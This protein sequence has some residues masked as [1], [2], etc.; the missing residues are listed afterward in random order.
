MKSVSVR[1][2]APQKLAMRRLRVGVTLFIR[3]GSQ[4]IWENGIFQNC[5]FLIALLQKSPVVETCYIVNGGPGDPANTGNFAA[6]A[7]SEIIS[8]DAAQNQLDV[9]IELSAQLDPEWGR[10]FVHKGGRIVGM[11][12]AND[13]VIDA[14]RIAFNLEPGL[15]MSGTPYQ[16]LW[17]LPAFE[18]TCAGYYAAATGRPVRVMQH[19]WSPT[20]LE[21]S[22][23]AAGTRHFAYAP[24][25]KRWRVAIME[26]N[27]CSV[28][29]CH[30]PLLACDVAHRMNSQ[31]LEVVRVFN[32]LPLKEN[33]TFV[34]FARSTDL[35]RQGLATFEG[36]YPIANIMG[37]MADAIVSHHWH[38]AQNYLYYEALYGGYPLIHNSGF[39]GDCGY[40]YVDYDPEDGGKAV[41]QALADHDRNL[42]DYRAQA[43]RLLARLDPLADAN[44]SAYSHALTNLFAD[45]FTPLPESG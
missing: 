38:N 27:I 42:D 1:G 20:L 9:I 5:F 25:K 12:V 19:L 28:K 18:R 2:S 21:R 11:R 16:E 15:L 14:E 35:V 24:G 33:H 4:S 39:I 45:E 43:S 40:R 7:N 26:P 29:T 36:R 6:D 31:A 32:A 37:P 10:A 41:L 3:E 23:Q 13:F 17:T 44:V 8:M 22:M 34:G 30:L